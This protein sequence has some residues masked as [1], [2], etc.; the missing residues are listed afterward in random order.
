MASGNSRDAT[1]II[2][3]SYCM[4]AATRVD[5]QCRAAWLDNFKP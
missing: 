1:I 5:F 4:D 2:A 3:W